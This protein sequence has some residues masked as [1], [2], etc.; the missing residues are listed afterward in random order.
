VRQLVR[1][2]INQ[3]KLTRAFERAVTLSAG[4]SW[5]PADH[6][7]DTQYAPLNPPVYATEGRPT[8]DSSWVGRLIVVKDAA[9]PGLLQTCLQNSGGT[10]SWVTLAIAES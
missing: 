2:G 1:R 4:G 6:N 9:A 5:A 3:G 10:Y 7:H 8:A